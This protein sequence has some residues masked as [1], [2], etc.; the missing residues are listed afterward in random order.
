MS[1]ESAPEPV[2]RAAQPGEVADVLRLWRESRGEPGQTD[3]PASLDALL[4]HERSALLIAELDG[5][6]VGSLI[7]VWDGWR[8][9][10]Y[11]LTV[12]PRLRRRGVARLLVGA[13]ESHL[14]ALG[15][16]RISA[17]VWR[18][19]GRAVAVW[20]SAGYEHEDGTGRF[21]KTIPWVS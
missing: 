19:D 12:H 10:M 11:R 14:H 16:R 4:E 15:A 20:R 13:G 17:L 7:A 2:I 5:R 9:N 8:G 1:G 21:V 6:V 3:D 18:D